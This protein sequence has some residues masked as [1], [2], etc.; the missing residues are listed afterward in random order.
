MLFLKKCIGSILFYTVLVIVRYGMVCNSGDVDCEMAFLE[1]FVGSRLV[2][3]YWKEGHCRCLVFR[4]RF[5]VMVL[6]F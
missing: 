3:N 6:A 5:K 2:G 4:R 1:R